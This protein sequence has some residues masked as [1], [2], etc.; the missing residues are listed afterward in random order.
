MTLLK[1][2]LRFHVL[3]YPMA[4]QLNFNRQMLQR[5]HL[6]P[7]TCHTVSLWK[8]MMFCHLIFGVQRLK[9]IMS[10]VFKIHFA[11]ICQL[12]R[13]FHVIPAFCNLSCIRLFTKLWLIWNTEFMKIQG[14]IIT[15]TLT[16][17]MYGHV[18]LYQ[19]D[20]WL[21]YQVLEN[22]FSRFD[23]K[24][25]LLKATCIFFIFSLADLYVGII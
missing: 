3:P 22:R 17:A 24:S 23:V 14:E 7:M 19:T 25:F 13:C 5:Y 15:P 2:L 16:F 20:T 10:P 1:L 8:T 6:T 18:V 4:T 9:V 12:N 11:I 21:C